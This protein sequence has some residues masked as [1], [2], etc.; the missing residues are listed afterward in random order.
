LA[1]LGIAGTIATSAFL[2]VSASPS[3][4]ETTMARGVTSCSQLRA[5]HPTGIAKSKKAP[6]PLS[7][8]GIKPFVCKHVYLQLKAGPQSQ[9]IRV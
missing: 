2:V 5:Q 3:T 1:S 7:V 4:A 6:R 9:Q 8:P